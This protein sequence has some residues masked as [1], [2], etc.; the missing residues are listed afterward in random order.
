VRGTFDGTRPSHCTPTVHI[1]ALDSGTGEAMTRWASYGLILALA[2]ASPA[3][4]GKS[5]SPPMSAPRPAANNEILRAQAAPDRGHADTAVAI[6]KDMIERPTFDTLSAVT[7][8]RARALYGLILSTSYLD[9][10]AALV[11]LKAATEMPCATGF[12]WVTRFHAAVGSGDHADAMR[13]VTV[14]AD[15]WPDLLFGLDYWIVRLEADTPDVPALKSQRSEMVA[16][17][18]RIGW[19]PD[20]DMIEPKAPDFTQR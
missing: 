20:P 5:S 10:T 9:D 12:S 11:Q 15:R 6:L 13:T 19:K 14:L 16:A 17:L 3:F 8:F 18:A 2:C 4:A 1:M 7:R